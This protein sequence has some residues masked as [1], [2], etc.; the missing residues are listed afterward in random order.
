[1]ISSFT[2][3]ILT[4]GAMDGAGVGFRDTSRRT[5]GEGRLAPFGLGMICREEVLVDID[6]SE[7]EVVVSGM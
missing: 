6:L 3:M 1:M 2:A 7:V 5:V 4:L